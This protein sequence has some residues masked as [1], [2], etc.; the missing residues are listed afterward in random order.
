[1]LLYKID[2]E[3]F[4]KFFIK[5]DNDCWVWQGT[6]HR[7]GY[8]FF[9]IHKK[10]VVA[11][12]VSYAL[13]KGKIPKG[14]GYHGICVCHSC[15]NPSC[16]NPNHLFLG[17]QKTNM[18]DMKRKGRGV[19]G[20]KIESNSGV[21]N[22]GSK[23]NKQDILDIRSKYNSNEYTITRLAYEFKTCLSVIYNIVNYITY[24]NI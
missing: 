5:K 11:H 24:K 21:N 8:G 9:R 15:D 2:K 22:Y 12:R 10:M 13:Y 3:R 1:M 18:K 23:F 4:E 7:Q 20:R 6:R 19:L 14:K 17:S 16:V